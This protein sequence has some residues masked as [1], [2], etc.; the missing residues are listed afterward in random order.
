MTWNTLST[1]SPDRATAVPAAIVI[2]APATATPTTQ[3]I[4][5]SA[6]SAPAPAAPA[7]V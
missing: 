6:T 4:D 3:V 2:D 5:A 1:A 7:P